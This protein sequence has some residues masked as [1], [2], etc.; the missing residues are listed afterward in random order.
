[1]K[2][3]ELSNRFRTHA[4]PLVALLA[5][6]FAVAAYLQALNFPFVSDD[7]MHITTNVKLLGLR[8][9]ELWRLFVEP[10]NVLREYLP[11]RELSFWL[12]FTLFGLNP[13]AFRIHNI[14]LYLLC[15]PFVYAA[16]LAL[17]RQFRPADA[18]SAPWAAACVTALFALHPALVE[19]VVWIT[20]RKYILPSLFAMLA[21][22]LA[23]RARRDDG[24]SPLP[25]VS[26]LLAF[27]AVMLSKSSYVGLA[28]VIAGVWLLHWFDLPHRPRRKILLAWPL[29][30]MLL[31]A[32]LLLTF[33]ALATG[34]S[35][36]QYRFGI[37]AV[38]R[39]LAVLGW[40]TRLALSPES[41]HLYYPVIGAAS[42]P[43]M[44]ALGVAVLAAIG[45]GALMFARRRSLAGFALILYF[46]LCLPY[47]QILPFVSPSMVQDRYLS[48][49]VWPL[50]IAVVAWIWR[51][52]PP[53]RAALLLLL[54]VPWY[55]Q[56][57]VRTPEWRSFESIVDADQKAFPGYFV[58]AAYRI[59]GVELPQMRYREAGETAQG[60]TDPQ[61]R[62]L[63]GKL[64]A[65]AHAVFLATNAK[66]D[67]P[68]ATALLWNLGMHLKQPPGD[69]NPNR[70]FELVRMLSGKY[71]ND[72][73]LDLAK[74]S[75]GGGAV[76]YNTGLWLLREGM[77][78]EAATQLRAAVESADLPASSR[79]TAFRNLGLALL[80]SGQ[81]TESEAA[82]R[83]ALTQAPPD[84]RAY[85]GLAEIYRRR[86]Q[87]D[88][89]R[90]A[91]ASCR[92]SGR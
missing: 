5:A 9:N 62:D 38:A 86:G 71:I 44:L 67:P 56:T 10:F 80:M 19:S 48:I 57:L 55:Y 51:L 58:P 63:L 59:L 8:A 72:L 16:T 74:H 73:W 21:V 22:W 33:I 6:I 92:P 34:E 54:A 39:P 28:P 12:D 11:L 84:A 24:L 78:L 87:I 53:Y 4:A 26:A 75:P 30:V 88:D 1:M 15:L 66:G 32:G 20:G 37:D 85:C 40:L 69:S 17:W 83:L 46:L 81:E 18:D 27:V 60:V 79:G 64:V 89:A 70:A 82:F 29:A 77:H 23:L 76:R 42:Y 13:A 68:Q 36:L 90:N 31:A 45:A 25:A 52:K 47:L 61:A 41:R 49:A 65:T 7:T 3:E 14:V 50:L 35:G 91:E 2:P 43:L